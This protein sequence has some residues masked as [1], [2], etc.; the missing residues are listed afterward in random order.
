MLPELAFADVPGC[1]CTRSSRRAQRSGARRNPRQPHVRGHVRGGARGA[2]R[3]PCARRA[4]ARSGERDTTRRRRA[5]PRPS[6]RAPI[7]SLGLTRS[8]ARRGWGLPAALVGLGSATL[9]VDTAPLREAVRLGAVALRARFREQRA[10]LAFER[11]LAHGAPLAVLRRAYAWLSLR[12]PDE[13]R[14]CW[15]GCARASP[16]SAET[17]RDWE[18]QAFAGTPNGALRA[19]PAPHLRAGA[20]RA[21]PARTGH[22]VSAIN[23]SARTEKGEVMNDTDR[24]QHAPA[25][26]R[27]VRPRAGRLRK[28]GPSATSASPED[29]AGRSAAGALNPAGPQEVQLTRP[30][31]S[32]TRPRWSRPMTWSARARRRSPTSWSSWETTS[33]TS[34]SAP[35][36]AA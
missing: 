27:D 2:L 3:A 17:L 6:G 18:E 32:R 23:P 35:T 10:F 4:L 30:C 9:A 8:A 29:A 28:E 14:T 12:L 25:R 24:E 31:T 33:A 5:G 11:A 15:R 13:P 20:P 34:T 16:P 22:A 36:T 1:A 7:G 21:R 26:G 19:P